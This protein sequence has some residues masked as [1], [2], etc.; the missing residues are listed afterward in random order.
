MALL[1]VFIIGLILGQLLDIPKEIVFEKNVNAVHVLSVIVTLFIALLI[2]VFFQT[3]KDINSVENKIIIKRMDQIIDILDSLQE[4]VG[5]GK[6]SISQAPAIVKRIYSSST[7]I[8]NYL[9]NQ[10]MNLPTKLL[11]IETE[12]RKLND[13]LTN[14]P[15]K[16]ID[17]L[18][19]PVQAIDNHYVYNC[20]R[21]VEIE[22]NIEDLKN[23]FFR[24]QLE[25]NKNLNR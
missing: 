16:N 12:T 1:A 6:V 4:I 21:I 18:T 9:D 19:I 7:F 25:L 10:H 2:T 3:H 13:L 8:W 22:K 5:S 15:A 11:A 23:L 14:T 20:S 24:A 17:L